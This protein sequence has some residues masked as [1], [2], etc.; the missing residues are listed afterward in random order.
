MNTKQELL[1]KCLHL[2]D[3]KMSALKEIMQDL[4]EA[5]FAETKSTAGDKHETARAMGQI[6]LENNQRQLQEMI[7]QQEILLQIDPNKPL[8]TVSLGS[9]VHTNRGNFFISAPLG[10]VVT[11][12]GDEFHAISAGSPLAKIMWNHKRSEEVLFDA[13]I[14]VIHQVE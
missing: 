9:V 8:R 3:E 10:K 7:H 6:E 12:A 5:V 13:Q 4:Q 14:L 1:H 2:V 11:N